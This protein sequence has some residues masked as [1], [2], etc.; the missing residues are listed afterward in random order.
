MDRVDLNVPFSEKDKAKAGGAKWDALHRTWYWP[1]VEVPESLSEYAI[2]GARPDS[3]IMADVASRVAA[4]ISELPAAYERK[5]AF[6]DIMSLLRPEKIKAVPMA[7][8]LLPILK[9]IGPAPAI[10]AGEE[11]LLDLVY[12]K[13]PTLPESGIAT[14]DDFLM[15]ALP[16]RLRPVEALD[17]I[18]RLDSGHVIVAGMKA[19]FTEELKKRNLLTA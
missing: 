10:L 1:G 15:M 18:K 4:L 5:L 13:H 12:G 17:K 2:P 14:L 6:A 8:H 9:D 16:K 19:V 7:E 11:W 3:A